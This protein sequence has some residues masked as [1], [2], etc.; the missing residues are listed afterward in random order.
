M[1]TQLKHLSL[2]ILFYAVVTTAFAKTKERPDSDYQNGVLVSFRTVEAGNNC[3]SSGSVKGSVDDSG[4]VE[5]T[6]N[7]SDSCHN[8]SVRLYTIKVGDSTFVIK[9]APENW[10][11]QS[12]LEQQLPGFKF[13]VRTQK[14]KLYIKVG[15]RESPFFLIEAR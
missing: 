13:K 4:N 8:I 15:D 2:C 11:R 5:G 10:N 12:V 3:S 1:K 6:T 14:D 9:H 7:S